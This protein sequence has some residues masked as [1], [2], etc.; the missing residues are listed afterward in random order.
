MGYAI[1]TDADGLEVEAVPGGAR[2]SALPRAWE[3]WPRAAGKLALGAADPEEASEGDVRR[4][5]ADKPW[6]WTGET[7]YFFCDVHADAAAFFRSLVASGGAVGVEGGELAFEL[8]E[9][10]RGAT[11]L[12]GGDCFDKGP[13]NLRLLGVL[14]SLIDQGAHVKILAGNHDIRTY[15]GLAYVG[16]KETHLAHLF[17]RMGKKTMRLVEEVWREYLEGRVD[18]STLL[19]DDEVRRILFPPEGWYED[20]PRVAG[21][22]INPKKLIKEITRI[23]EKTA[24]LEAFFASKRMTFG[25]AYAAVQKC[26]ELFLEPDGEFAWVFRDMTLAYR[27]GS[28]LF[29]HAGVDD[30][31]AEALRRDGVQSVNDWFRRLIA[32]DKLF[33]LYHGPVGN[34]VRTKYRDIDLP[35]TERGASALRAAGLYAIVHGHK[36]ILRGQRLVLREGVLNF[37]CDASIDENTRVLEGLEGPGAAV[38]VFRPDARILAVSTDYPYVKVFD[39]AD[40]C[41][42]VIIA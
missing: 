10:G 34:A 22:W 7:L 15:V 23:R 12:I 1:T 32:E 31:V 37:E 6:V 28:V 20:F 24:D 29:V 9:R 14:R 27:A 2:S 41:P 21:R 25:M 18:P 16:R 13:H 8:S 39:P 19:P 5:A 30:E 33:E 42:S 40:L 17:V 3:S 26:R 11:F 38:T 36:N 4:Y 35:L